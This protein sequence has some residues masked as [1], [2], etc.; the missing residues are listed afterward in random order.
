V[1]L[2][3][4]LLMVKQL[5][6]DGGANLALHEISMTGNLGRTYEESFTFLL[7]LQKDTDKRWGCWLEG[8]DGN[9]VAEVESLV[10]FTFRGS[11]FTTAELEERA[12][13]AATHL[14]TIE[15]D[16]VRMVA[17]MLCKGDG[18]LEHEEALSR[19]LTVLN[20]AEWNLASLPPKIRKVIGR[21]GGR[22]ARLMGMRH[23]L[24]R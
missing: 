21:V 23:Q 1:M 24:L 3:H 2:S 17:A 22:G 15:A 11:T 13:A 20:K 5:Y 18:Y 6:L 9:G 19:T 10:A 12:A 16:I 7:C 14:R 4:T 8:I